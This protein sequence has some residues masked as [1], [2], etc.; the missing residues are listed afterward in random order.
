MARLE[1]QVRAAGPDRSVLLSA[2]AGSGKTRVLVR[3]II[4]LLA[5]GA[6]PDELAAITFTEKAAAQMKDRLFDALSAAAWDGTNSAELLELGPHD[7]PY[8]LSKTPEDIV[9]G[10]MA[11][12]DALRVSTIHAFCLSLLRQFPLEAGLPA[13]FSVM[14]DV[15]I[16]LRR[17]A[18]VDEALDIASGDLLYGPL[19][20][21]L[22]AGYSVRSLKE[23][24]VGA[25]EKRSLLCMLE[26]DHGGFE[27]LLS[28]LEKS[29]GNEGK[30]RAAEDMLARG[31]ITEKA[32]ALQNVCK[33]YDL[34]D[35]GYINAIE[36]I[37][38]IDSLEKLPD[39]FGQAAGYFYTKDF[40]YLTR[41]PVSKDA[42]KK[43]V[44]AVSPS[45]KGKALDEE[46]AEIK[47]RHDESYVSLR[48]A[49]TELVRLHDEISSAEALLAFLNIYKRAEEL[50]TQGNMREGLVDYDDLEI[51][52][53]RLLS[54][55]DALR[56]LYRVESRVLHY[57]VDE[58]QDTGALQWGI[59]RKLNDEVFA[60]QG[61]EGIK[62][63]TLF[64][65]GDK[66]QSIYRFRK[67]DYRLMDALKRM[68]E[69][70]VEPGRRD[71]PELDYNFRCV[72]EILDVVDETFN[73]LMGGEYR[74]A[75]PQKGR[76]SGGVT[77]R[78]VPVV[79]EADALAGEIES[80][81]GL[82]VWDDEKCRF[83]A[84]DYGDMAVLL[85]TRAGLKSYEEAF[86]AWGIPYKV[87][88]GV[89]FFFQDEVQA[90]VGL[91]NFLENPADL[92][93]LSAALKSPLFGL[94]DGDIEPLF[95][96]G[97]P[98]EALHGINP[99]VGGMVERWRGLVGFV[100]TGELVEC[101]VRESGALSAFGRSSG[102]AAVLNVEKLVG[103]AHD[104]DRRGG[105][106][107]SEFTEWVKTY[108]EKAEL[109]TADV[110][111]PGWERF[112]SIMTVHAAKG[113]EFPIVFLPGAARKP[114]S[115]VDRF[116][117]SDGVD[118]GTGLSLWTDA[119]MGENPA[120]KAAKEKDGIAQE[121][122]SK[123]LLYVA[124]TRA[125]QYLFVIA[126]GKESGKGW[127][128]AKGT[129][130]SQLFEAK[131]ASLF[132][133]GPE[134]GEFPALYRYPD[135][136]PAAMPGVVNAEPGTPVTSSDEALAGRTDP[137]PDTGGITFITPSELVAG[138]PE[139]TGPG[140]QY[141]A[142]LRGTVIHRA[143]EDFG[144]SGRYDPATAAKGL[145]GFASL[146]RPARAALLGDVGKTLDALFEDKE[147]TALI[148]GGP[149]RHHE[150]PLLLKRGCE[151]VAG[152][153]DLVIVEGD[154]A[155]VVDYKTGLDGIPAEE[156]RA[157]YAPQLEAYREAVKEAFGAKEVL[158]ILLLVDRKAIIPV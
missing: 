21:L 94:S 127:R 150:I 84:A 137:L 154:K 102:P 19:G 86:R 54:G 91:L 36:S 35:P 136:F 55:P 1:E 39:V 10:L 60:G 92:V 70:S 75:R 156:I 128:P 9:S 45:L 100:R 2:S 141:D 12:P 108:R 114:R 23:A 49:F 143:L 121:E 5:A 76:G 22:D 117:M 83:R 69:E 153:A 52:A 106:G 146:E 73:A 113:L 104:F 157:A 40:S 6:A 148:S 13:E 125:K 115:T 118:G 68:M 105:A 90:I 79:Q 135:A 72:P 38:E 37:A 130:L 87:A 48:D 27:G 129:W 57:L 30:L 26:T 89:G 8:P 149:G 88:G 61:A 107:L 134:P 34:R 47:S 138:L 132:A 46:A 111:L 51:S 66:K 58:F 112:V 82:P 33:E 16:P 32:R 67:A 63:P 133:G 62:A 50:Y 41:L 119:L 110:E 152:K 64:A 11:N 158:A 77:L 95:T 140:G 43:S 144:R 17:D 96:G 131:P 101:V 145:P 151:V 120:Y 7:A 81:L 126:G 147:I 97:D 123:R 59:L 42:A 25:M 31:E 139:E 24:L 56:I 18:A 155:T 28:L 98:L 85:R 116:I 53:Y 74:H 99:D 142:K 71:F 122:E 44:K 109:A 80:A 29:L 78:V 93:S 103:I 65:V 3:R 20:T 4:H 15:E 14:D 124:M